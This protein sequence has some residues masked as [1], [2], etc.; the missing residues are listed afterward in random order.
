V[1]MDRIIWIV[2]V[3]VSV[4]CG[5]AGPTA[6]TSDAYDT[7]SKMAPFYGQYLIKH[8]GKPPADEKAFREFLNSKQDELAKAGLTVDK[9]FVSPRNGEPFEWVYGKVPP[10]N[11]GGMTYLGYESTDVGGKRFVFMSRGGQQ[12]ID[13]AEF[14]NAFPNAK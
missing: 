13:A 8:N 9:M 14:H 10:P 2:S 4:G 1:K 12:E 6:K 5:G 11:A 7:L 3:I